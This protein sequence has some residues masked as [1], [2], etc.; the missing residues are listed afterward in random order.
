MGTNDRG[1]NKRN[2]NKRGSRA[3]NE[4]ELRLKSSEYYQLSYMQKTI[5]NDELLLKLGEKDIELSGLRRRIHELEKLI[6]T[7]KLS[8]LKQKKQ[9]SEKELIQFRTNLAEGLGLQ[10]LDEYIVD[11]ETFKLTHEREV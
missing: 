11:T 1:S 6:Y 9:A 7:N 3:T 5:E 10:S 4:A 8:L 2:G